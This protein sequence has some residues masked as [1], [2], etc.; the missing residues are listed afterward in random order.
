MH[1]ICIMSL[2]SIINITNTFNKVKDKKNHKMNTEKPLN[3]HFY[4]DIN[5]KKA[6]YSPKWLNSFLQ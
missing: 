1:K 4:N 3:A 5:I 6:V 2:L